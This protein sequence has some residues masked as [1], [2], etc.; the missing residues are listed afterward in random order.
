M[1][2]TSSKSRYRVVGLET[3]RQNM[4][5]S[6]RQHDNIPCVL[7]VRFRI[8][9]HPLSAR[10]KLCNQQTILITIQQGFNLLRSMHYYRIHVKVP[11]FRVMHSVVESF[12]LGGD[13]A[14]DLQ[15][16]PITQFRVNSVK[17]IVDERVHLG[18]QQLRSLLDRRR[19]CNRVHRKR[20]RERVQLLEQFQQ[21]AFLK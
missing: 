4:A 9:V 2:T 13:H 17:L 21:V 1:I 10:C 8:V 11:V 5:L 14:T 3:K 18:D 12:V 20:R 7:H 16:H 6:I 19:R 15:L